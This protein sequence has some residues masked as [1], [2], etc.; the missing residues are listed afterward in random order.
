M[1]YTILRGPIYCDASAL[2]KLYIPEAESE[3]LRRQIAGRDDLVVSDLAVT[4]IV[5]ALARRGRERTS[6]PTVAA[7]AAR[8]IVQSLDA[9]PYQRVELTRDIHRRAEQLLLTLTRTPLRAADALHLALALSARTATMAVFDLR[10]S[11]AARA[12]G[13]D[14]YPK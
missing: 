8:T 11:A 10:L 14:V 6:S 5:S 3:D 9:A 7:R 2:A 13:L 1:P 4:E 12:I